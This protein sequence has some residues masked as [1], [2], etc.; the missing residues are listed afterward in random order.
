MLS[1]LV[2]LCAACDIF[3]ERKGTKWVAANSF[4]GPAKKQAFNFYFKDP[5]GMLNLSF[6]GGVKLIG[7]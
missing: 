6:L 3:S 7:K 1:T 4:A 2:S 5:G